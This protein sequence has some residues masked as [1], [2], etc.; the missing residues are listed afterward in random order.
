MTTKKEETGLTEESIKDVLNRLT[1]A[2]E[3]YN[4]SHSEELK[5]QKEFLS[6]LKKSGINVV[7]KRTLFTS[8]F[9]TLLFTLYNVF[10]NYQQLT[11][12]KLFLLRR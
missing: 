2:L 3:N 1:I 5:F 7:L 6:E 11:L 8:L 12:I 9:A 10:L 4:A